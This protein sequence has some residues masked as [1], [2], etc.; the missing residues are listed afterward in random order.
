MY[1]Y[2]PRADP[3]IL[4]RE[5]G[6]GRSPE[7]SAEGESAGPPPE[8]F[9]KL[10]ATSCNLAYILGSEWPWMSFKIGPLQNKKTVSATIS[11]PDI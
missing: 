8:N 1:V 5:P 6:K 7:P 10:D 4:E 11:K 2:V 9:E 3:G